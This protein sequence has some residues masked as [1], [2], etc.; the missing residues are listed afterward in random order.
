MTFTIVSAMMTKDTT[1]FD[2]M[3]ELKN[4]VM[5]LLESGWICFGK[6]SYFNNGVSQAMIPATLSESEYS[7]VSFEL[8]KHE[9]NGTRKLKRIVYADTCIK[10]YKNGM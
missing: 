9:A 2:V 10:L 7:N 8:S 5:N 4:K 6:I 3:E 1:T